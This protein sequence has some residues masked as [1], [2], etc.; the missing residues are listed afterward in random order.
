MNIIIKITCFCLFLILIILI[1]TP[2]LK[3]ILI[4]EE[5]THTMFV[6]GYQSKNVYVLGYFEKSQV[7]IDNCY[8][9]TGRINGHDVIQ[10]S[11][12]NIMPY[13][14]LGLGIKPLVN[15]VDLSKLTFIEKSQFA[16]SLFLLISSLGIF[17]LL[18]ISYFAGGGLPIK[19][20]PLPFAILFF[21]TSNQLLIGSSIQPQLDGAFGFLLLG[22]SSLFLYL[23]SNKKTL[24][25]TKFAL[26]FLAGTIS[27][28]C[29]NEWSL[30]LIASVIFILILRA[31]LLGLGLIEGSISN[32]KTTNRIF[33]G[34]ILGAIF[35]MALCYF[36]SPQDYIDGY[37]LMMSI[38]S[39]DPYTS[40]MTTILNPML[41]PV[42]LSLFIGILLIATNF[43]N[44]LSKQP[45]ILLLYI[46]GCSIF[47][48]YLQSGHTGDGFLRYYAPTIILCTSFIIILIPSIG[49]LVK[50]FPGV[51]LIAPTLV[52][53]SLLNANSL[54]QR[55]KLEDFS[56]TVPIA[57][58]K[59]KE[60]FLEAN[61]TSIK[62][63]DAVF[64]THSGIRY[65]FPD[66]NFIAK[67]VGYSGAVGLIEKF[68]PLN[69]KIHLVEMQ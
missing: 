37:R 49:F 45:L 61:A 26:V 50:G 30:A 28:F 63:Q 60:I 48:G 23:A 27:A 31:I 1:R 34:L 17:C 24:F 6:V 39:Q 12:R 8:A 41:R 47:T 67:D 38:S 40:L 52:I 20:I 53:A 59:V 7:I 55:T 69:P 64:L 46:W 3:Q 33:G 32:K 15:L 44:L 51:A 22:A 18:L 5:G 16:R 68:K 13:C 9:V 19:L 29:K 57:P 21:F 14:I 4:G 42:L 54:S 36:A 65:Y 56:I 10:S 62:D 2:F 66:L 25:L 11:S 43:K 58:T 35:G